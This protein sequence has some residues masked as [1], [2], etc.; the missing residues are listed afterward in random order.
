VDKEKI[1]KA[2]ASFVKEVL[3]DAEKGHDWLHVER[4]WKNGKQILQ[5]EPGDE[6]TVELGLLLHDI[7]DA[8]FHD[9]DEEKGP[10]MART[11]LEGLGVAESVIVHVEKIIKHISFHKNVDGQKWM[12]SE[13][14]IVQDA[15]RLDALGAI[16]VARCFT[17]GGFKGRSMYDPEIPPNPDM[18]AE[19]YLRVDR[20]NTTINHFYHK[21]LKLKGMMNTPTG[22]KLA[23]SRHRFLE[24]FLAQF[25][26]EIAGEG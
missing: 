23:E 10:R 16:G 3:Q 11:F 13:L 18:S 24:V 26:R 19:E 22:R 25:E 12:S 1:I 5:F 6:L 2:T 8:K 14:A 4:V 17:Y 7:A 20:E 15:D 21:L 9:G